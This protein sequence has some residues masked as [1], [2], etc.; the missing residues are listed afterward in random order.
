MDIKAEDFKY[1]KV[2]VE[3]LT[4]LIGPESEFFDEFES[5]VNLIDAGSKFIDFY[6]MQLTNIDEAVEFVNKLVNSFEAG[7]APMNGFF[8]DETKKFKEFMEI[9]AIVGYKFFM[10][11]H[12][13]HFSEVWPTFQSFKTSE[14]FENKLQDSCEGYGME[15]EE[16]EE[17]DEE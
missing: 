13:D 9:L 1:E 17:N 10:S 8:T 6:T 15:L 14:A 4:D 5:M 11:V 2:T 16:N 12:G 3:L 7:F